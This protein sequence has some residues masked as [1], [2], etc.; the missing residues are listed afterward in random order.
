M[1][2]IAL[3][4]KASGYSFPWVIRPSSSQ[5]DIDNYENLPEGFLTETS[6]QGLVVPW[7]PQL[8]VL[9]HGSVCAFMRMEINV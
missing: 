5:G 2:E 4:L 9:S 3:G 1:H 8:Q 7:R 6:G